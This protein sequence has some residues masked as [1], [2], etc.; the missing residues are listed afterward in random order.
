MKR[1]R[2]SRCAV[3]LLAWVGMLVGVWLPGAGRAAGQD[4]APS[5]APATVAV[6]P[7]T[8]NVVV[9]LDASGSMNTRMSVDSEVTRMVA[10]KAALKE[11]LKGVPA[12]TQIG[13]LV[14]GA[15]NI[16]SHLVVGGTSVGWAYRLGPRDDAKLAA[17]IDLPIAAYKTPLGACI[18]EGMGVLLEQRSS[19]GGG[20]TYRLLVVTDGEADDPEVVDKHVPDAAEKGIT[21]DVIGVAMKTTHSLATKV[22]Q[23]FRADDPSA[24][25]KAVATVF[26]EVASSGTDAQGQ[27]VFDVI[28]PLPDAVAEAMIK[29]LVESAKAGP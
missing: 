14:F 12:D 17:A 10:A 29:A 15:S 19:Q 5:R 21:I 27:N 3:R 16:R 11:A 20:G 4:A 6:P 13:L 2:V 23:Y 28:A 8:K 25:K 26:A 22:H 24:L 1:V 7:E 9:L 18:F